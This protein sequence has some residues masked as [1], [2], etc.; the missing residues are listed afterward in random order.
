MSLFS[1]I[2]KA[3]GRKAAEDYCASD[4][5]RKMVEHMTHEAIYRE[6]RK[7]F[8]NDPARLAAIEE[9]ARA[10]KRAAAGASE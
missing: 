3:I 1:R 9:H 8:A 6:L 2:G 10:R 5:F 4:P 7:R